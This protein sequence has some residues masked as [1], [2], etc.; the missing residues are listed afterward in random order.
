MIVSLGDRE[1]DVMSALWKHGPSTVQ[2]VRDRLPAPLAYNTV[3]TILRN[4]EQKG[5]AGHTPEGRLHRYFALLDEAAVNGSLLSRLLH[6]LFHGSPLGLLTQLV[7][8]EQL[9]PQEL[10][11]L[12]Q[13]LDDRLRQSDGAKQGA[14]TPDMPPS[15]TPSR[16]K[17]K[18][19]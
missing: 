9:S 19:Q 18:K 10:R 13:L 4:L 15:P 14:A 12:Q 11:A 1:L 8:S 17:G 5:M 6:K 3:L 16:R 2:E 7:D